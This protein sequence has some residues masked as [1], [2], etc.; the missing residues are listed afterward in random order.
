MEKRI[1]GIFLLIIAV[2]GFLIGIIY[3]DR[4]RPLPESTLEPKR[5]PFIPEIKELHN[6]TIAKKYIDTWIL[7]C[8]VDPPIV[9]PMTD[10]YLKLEDGYRFKV[11]IS[12]Y[13]ASEVG[14]L[15]HIWKATEQCWYGIRWK[16]HGTISRNGTLVH[17]W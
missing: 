13:K 3:L 2:L 4:S 5:E 6:S 1:L 16:E 7:I 15:V 14:D 12:T 9:I 11:K 10:Y 17:E 8:G